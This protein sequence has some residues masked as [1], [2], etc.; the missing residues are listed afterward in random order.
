MMNDEN[1]AVSAPSGG[2][3]STC[4]YGHHWYGGGTCPLCDYLGRD[5]L[6]EVYDE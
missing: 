4:Q 3:Y 6:S 1:G 5:N 2:L